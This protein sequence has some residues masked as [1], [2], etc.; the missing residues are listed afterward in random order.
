[1]PPQSC[2]ATGWIVQSDL[3]SMFSLKGK[4]ALVSGASRGIGLAIA[5]GLAG[6]GA[7]VTAF[8]R[9]KESADLRPDD[10]VRYLSC[11]I[12]DRARS[13]ALVETVY[14][15]KGALDVYVHA[16]GITLP[17]DGGPQSLEAFEATLDSNLVGAYS[18]F[19]LV[20]DKMTASG[21]GSVIFLT[22]IGSALAFPHNPGYA[23]SK[24]GLRMLAKALAVDVGEKKIRV[25]AIAPGYVRTAMTEASHADPARREARSAHTILGRWGTPDDIVGAAIFLASDASAYITAQDIFVDGGWTAKG[26]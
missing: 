9:S 25:N 8:A 10:P 22:S 13:Q 2:A 3:A 26:L 1:M 5:R 21:G 11:D 14:A 7:D 19:L 16:A 12:T 20:R 18:M 17:D 15:R 4:T 6:A 24:G 23:A